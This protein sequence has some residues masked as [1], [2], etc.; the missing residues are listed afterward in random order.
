[1]T[2]VKGT[3]STTMK[4]LFIVIISGMM[5]LFFLSGYGSNVSGQDKPV[6]KSAL[7]E[8][9]K[10]IT[11]RSCIDCHSDASRNMMAK[12]AL[13]FDGWG[14]LNNQKKLSK[15]KKIG[16]M[17]A[18]GKMPPANYLSRVP[19]KKL[20]QEEIEVIQKWSKEDKAE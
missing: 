9:V 3:K 20:S 11:D 5:L 13:N 8:A 10:K 14:D 1:M 17:V 2:N 19:D 4:K 7:P 15:M 18:K 6:Q 12:T 16:D